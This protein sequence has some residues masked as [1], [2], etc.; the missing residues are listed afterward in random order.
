MR[1]ANPYLLNWLWALPVV[2][3]LLK[4]FLR[5]RQ[6]KMAL[7]ADRGL[8]DQITHEFSLKNLKRKNWF[9]LFSLL[10]LIVALARPQWGYVIEKVKQQGLDII[11]AVDVSKSMLTKDVRPNRLERTKLAMKDLLKKINGDRIGLMAFAGEAFMKCPLTNDYAGFSM[12]LDDLGADSVSLGGSN[13][14][15]AI[16]EALKIFGKD[17]LKYKAFVLLT[18]GE[19]QQGEAVAAAKKARELGV[20][21]FTIGIG[22]KEGDLIQVA[23]SDGSLEFLKDD[24]GNF[25][26]SHLNEELLQKI[27]YE[28][29]GAYVRSSGA[30]FGLDYLYTNELSKWAKRSF[31]ERSEKRYYEQFQ[32]P[33]AL[34]I[35]LLMLSL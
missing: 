17:Q 23:G 3:F 5:N 11:L 14:A 24:H 30:E 21:I 7:F 15:R 20:K 28:T 29:S 4:I 13:L 10:F 32:W 19:E 16:E 22:T 34:S 2:W 1:F 9:L 33:L 35:I 31:E 27:A 18:D 8:L 26:K 6:K 12:S 25:V